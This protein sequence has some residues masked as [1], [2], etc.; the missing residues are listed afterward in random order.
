M[1]AAPAG[2]GQLFYARYQR[3]WHWTCSRIVSPNG[4]L[5]PTI[6]PPLVLS[7]E[8]ITPRDVMDAMPG[9]D[10]F[11]CNAVRLTLPA[12]VGTARSQQ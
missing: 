10:C 6:S 1:A 8:A 4:K 3:G 12:V 9:L 5:V 11:R 7:Q 2:H